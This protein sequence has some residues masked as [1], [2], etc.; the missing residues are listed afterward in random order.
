MK[1]AVL[2][3]A[4]LVSACAVPYT[5]EQLAAKAKQDSTPNLCAVTLMRISE[6][7][8]NAAMNEIEAR[9]GTCDWQQAQAIAET[10]LAKKQAEADA[11]QAQ[12]QQSMMMM[13]MGAA[14][15]QQS[16]PHY[17]APPPVQTSCIR[18]GIYMNCTSY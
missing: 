1:K 16:G 5:P 6:A 13:G 2:A 3:L 18:Q 12:M 14:L 4:V 9:G 7:V 17:Y 11:K 10:Q 15:L 8:T